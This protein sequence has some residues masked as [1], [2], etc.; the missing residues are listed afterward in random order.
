MLSRY[1]EVLG[2]PG[3]LVMSLAGLIAR[4][5]YAII[6]LG[7]VL[8]V[9][10]RTG[11][12]ALAG[13]LSATGAV[14]YAL[15][16]P[17]LGRLIDRFGQSRVL[18]ALAAA[19]I[20][21][22]ASFVLFVLADAPAPILFAAVAVQGACLPNVGSLVRARWAHLLAAEPAGLKT[23]FALESVVD[24]LTFIVG[25]SIAAVLAVSVAEWSPLAASAAVL[26]LGVALLVG[27]RRTEPPSSSHGPRAGRP[28]VLQ[29]GALP[30]TVVFFLTG[31]VF[32][33]WEIATVA[34]AEEHHARGA[35]GLLIA[36]CA[37]GSAAAGFALGGARL[38]VPLHR[39]LIAALV[40]LAVVMLPFPFIGSLWVMGGALLL[41]GAAVSPVL[42][43]AYELVER[44]VPSGRITEGLVTMQ[45]GLGVGLA[46]SAAAAGAVVD[47][48]GAN[49][50]FLI[51]TVC[52]A[53]ALLVALLALGT[54]RRA[55]RTADE[56]RAAVSH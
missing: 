31:C 56:R 5:P 35:T 51:A 10:S 14:C 22:L 52:A 45:A 34:F 17:L 44:L 23:A 21:A 37:F 54:L 33:S 13:A 30:V 47:A 7:I 1:R 32:G 24:E 11:S 48:H 38:R 39:Q 19:E 2:R 25:P 41:A 15:V 20:V 3:A 6:G 9:V 50:A 18:P 43:T 29:R 8:F 40:A 55:L 26:V 53:V 27:Q 42:I 12:Y 36:L 4:F 46:V 49:E 16:G 28:A